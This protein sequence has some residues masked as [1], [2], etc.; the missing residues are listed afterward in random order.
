MVLLGNG[1]GTFQTGQSYSVTTNATLQSIL[2]GD[3]NGDGK[4]DLLVGE[5]NDRVFILNGKGDGTFLP[6]VAFPAGKAVR[7]WVTGDFDGD[8]SLDLAATSALSNAVYVTLNPPLVALYPGGVQFG[9]QQVG[10]SSPALAITVSN[11]SGAPLQI[12]DI[13]ASGAFTL[14]NGCPTTLAPGANCTLSA[15]FVPLV[16]G[17]SG[18]LLMLSDNS[19]GSPQ[20]VTLHGVGIGGADASL[21]PSSLIFDP[22]NLGT[23]SAAKTMTLANQGSVTLDVASIV[24]NGDFVATNNCPPALDAGSQCTISVTFMPTVAGL[25]TGV[26]TITDNAASSPQTAALTGAGEAT[27]VVGLSVP[28]LAFGNQHVNSTSSPQTVGLSNSGTAPLQISSINVTGNFTVFHDCPATL[29]A[30]ANC[31]ISVSFAPTVVGSLV[32]SLTITDNAAN[33][34][35]GLALTGTGIAPEAAVSPSSLIFAGQVVGTPGNVQTLTL[36]NS[37]SAILTLSNVAITRPASGDFALQNQCGGPINP[38]ANCGISVAFTPT[39]AGT[40]TANLT[41]TTNAADGPQAVVLTGMGTDFSLNVSHGSLPTLNVAPGQ[42]AVSHITLSPVGMKGTVS[43]TCTGAPA[44]STCQVSPLTVTLDGVTPVDVMVS[45]Q[46]A[47]PSAAMFQ[48][49]RW[50]GEFGS[51]GGLLG[52]VMLLAILALAASITRNLRRR[53]AWGLAMLLLA[54]L[55][56]P[57]C[58]GGG[59]L[60]SGLGESR[61]GTPAGSYLLTLT[62]TSPGVSH[63]MALTL[64]VQN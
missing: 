40:R 2:V 13:T 26:L 30:G 15:A 50:P 47:A 12:T 49:P 32:G 38:G 43:L 63:S 57:G 44:E 25:R 27:P 45:V 3:Y 22:Q 5:S 55:L 20:Y 60:S 34:P 19:P 11:S 39:A 51:H 1:D 46:T 24:A 37:G 4:L 35:Q 8:G 6:P 61:H 9:S 23:T 18:G 42:Q 17:D 41:L 16:D 29:A 48:S 7:G 62:A 56:L 53:A 54:A 31:T 64:T 59:Q 33:S 14:L 10:G 58:G 36:S 28:S 52:S 21:S